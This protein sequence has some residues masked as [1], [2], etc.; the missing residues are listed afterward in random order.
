M[1]QPSELASIIK[2]IAKQK[3]IKIRE[4]LSNI[5]VNVNAVSTMTSR[6]SYPSIETMYKIA[7]HL[8][9]SIDFLL[10]R[11]EIAEVNNGSSYTMENSPMSAQ[12]NNNSI[13]VSSAANETLM[14]RDS[15]VDEMVERFNTL[16][17][18]DK[19]EIMQLINSKGR[20]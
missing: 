17:F 8:N 3:N 11:T 16:S 5:N 10:G 19:L 14:K 15:M 1:R 20:V 6:G 7:E 9:V 13:N 18:E 4:M 2:E 12:G